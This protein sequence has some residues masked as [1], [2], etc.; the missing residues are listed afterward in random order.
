MQINMTNGTLCAVGIPV[1]QHADATRQ[2]T[3]NRNFTCTHHRNM[4]PAHLTS[5]QRRVDGNEV[6]SCCE[7]GTGNVFRPQSWIGA[8]N[9]FQQFLR[10]SQDSVGLICVNGGRT[11]NTSVG[12]HPPK[13]KERDRR[14][15]SLNVQVGLV[16]CP[17][18]RHQRRPGFGSRNKSNTQKSGLYRRS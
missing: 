1:D 11:T 2:S 3:G 9:G 14:S 6:V 16:F 15:R 8:R 4:I 13:N 12:H 7:E 18:K 10:S 5:S 17:L